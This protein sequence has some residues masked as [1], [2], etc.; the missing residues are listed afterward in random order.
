MKIQTFIIIILAGTAAA[1]PVAC[2][3]AITTCCAISYGWWNPFLFPT[4][5]AQTGECWGV[6]PPWEHCGAAGIAAGLTP[7]P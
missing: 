2:M 5:M 3:G 6:S 7:T 1:G 4:C